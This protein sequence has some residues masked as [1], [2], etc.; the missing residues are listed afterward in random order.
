MRLIVGGLTGRTGL[1]V[2]RALLAEPDVEIVAGVGGTSSG[3]DLSTV[4]GEKSDGKKIFSSVGEAFREAPAELYLDFTHARA[5]ERNALEAVPL[6]LRPLIGTTGLRPEAVS[7]L[8]EAI[9]H[10]R[11]A[12]AV[13][14]NF[15]LGSALLKKMSLE[16]ARQYPHV[17]IIEYHGEHKRDKPSGTAQDLAQAFRHEGLEVPVHSVRLPGMVAHQAVIFGSAGETLTLRHDVT[18]RSAYARGVHL[19]AQALLERTGFFTSLGDLLSA[20]TLSS[21]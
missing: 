7:A 10:Y 3:R 5:A 4:F 15:S 2:A 12:G 9:N 16:L 14:A 11:T 17:E 19:A 18:S 1:E 6:G 20:P 21:P 8:K 13:I